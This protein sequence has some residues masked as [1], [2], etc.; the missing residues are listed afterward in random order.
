MHVKLG[1]RGLIVFL[2]A[3]MQVLPQAAAVS[4]P[5]IEELVLANHI[6][7]NEGI[8]DGY[9][10]VSVR[11]PDNP[12]HYLLARAGAPAL[13]TASDITEYDLDSKP[14]TNASA[15]GYTERF[16]HGEIYKARSDVMAVV[17][18]H[19]SEVI[20]FAN[21]SV[22]LQPMHHM[23]SFIGAGVP[24]FEIRTAGGET[25]MLIRTPQLGRALAQTL[26]GKS[27]VLMRGHGAAIVAPSLHI[28]VGRSYYLNLNA[29]LQMQAL[30]LGGKVNYLDS[31]ESKKAAIDYERSWDS[32]KRDLLLA[33]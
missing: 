6:L 9:G 17:H 31:E 32:W 16:I 5:A 8:L 10:H 25:D 21:T 14:V 15:T 7:A 24:V 2:A 22:P 1:L 33:H 4:K 28:V 19:C 13:V 18:C 20:P 29:R 27:A 12:N 30:Q 11:D 3:A 26:E 23:G